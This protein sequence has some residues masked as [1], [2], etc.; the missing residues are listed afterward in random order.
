MGCAAP[1]A[2]RLPGHEKEQA[3][4][5]H[6]LAFPL[7]TRPLPARLEI[8]HARCETGQLE[9][10]QEAQSRTGR[11]SLPTQ[12]PTSTWFL[13]H[14]SRVSIYYLRSSAQGLN[15]T[16]LVYCAAAQELFEWLDRVDRNG[17]ANAVVNLQGRGSS[18]RRN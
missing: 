8:V 6:E 2:P 3:F 13:L 16:G 17:K 14:L 18:Y 7:P 12:T 15:R 10:L 1:Q 11:P 4:H 9:L 5:A